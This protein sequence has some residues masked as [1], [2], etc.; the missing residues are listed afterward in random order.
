MK[1]ESFRRDLRR[2]LLDY[3][4]ASGQG[5]VRY[6]I[7]FTAAGSLCL[8]LTAVVALFIADPSFAEQIHNAF[9]GDTF[10]VGEPEDARTGANRVAQTKSPASR[11]AQYDDLQPFLRDQFE[12]DQNLVR[13]WV[14][15]SAGLSQE[16]LKAVDNLERFTVSRF[17]LNNGRW[18]QIYTQLPDENKVRYVRY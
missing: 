12:L 4:A 17:K 5:L 1:V 15:Q 2:S 9:I 7:A 3:G 13:T 8:V 10:S 16:D 14:S 18:V 6:R 11:P